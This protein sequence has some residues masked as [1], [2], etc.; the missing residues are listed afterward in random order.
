MGIT[1]LQLIVNLFWGIMS[2]II[3]SL[4]MN[5]NISLANNSSLFFGYIILMVAS[6]AVVKQIDKRNGISED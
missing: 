5:G 2:V 1:K 6:F 4:D 3:L